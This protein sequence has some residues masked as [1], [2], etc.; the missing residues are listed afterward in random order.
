MA[1]KYNKA[2]VRFNNGNGALLCNGC[3]IILS[4]GFNHNDVE[5]YCGACYEKAKIEAAQDA[6]DKE[7][8]SHWDDD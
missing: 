7:W 6:H 5:H 4:Y 2:D 1:V 3:R 8:Y